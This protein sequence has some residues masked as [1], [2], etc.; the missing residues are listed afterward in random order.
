MI[1]TQ[2]SR[3]NLARP[4]DT[5]PPGVDGPSWAE[6]AV[7][8]VPP[9]EPQAAGLEDPAAEFDKYRKR[10]RKEMEGH[11]LRAREAILSDF[12]EVADNLERA[13]AS[14]K[15]GD[16]KDAKSVR[17]GVD[18]VL[19]LLRS[20]LER[21]SVTAIETKGKPFDPRVHHA[22]SQAPSTDATPGTVLHEVQ[23][24]YW[25][26][27]RLLRPA[28]VVVASTPASESSASDQERHTSDEPTSEWH[29]YRRNR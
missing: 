24:G 13:I 9:P 17:D 10:V 18:L 1:D 27:E 16:K 12:L 20:K 21:Y 8:A 6:E 23:K 15:E 29:G 26:G 25:M 7:A 11:E 22:V 19:R 5:S 2:E 3:F 28:V 4:P 14:W